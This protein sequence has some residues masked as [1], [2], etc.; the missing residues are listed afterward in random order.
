MPMTRNA[1]NFAS[2]TFGESPHGTVPFCSA[3]AIC[4]NTSGIEMMERRDPGE[5]CFEKEQKPDL[6][7]LDAASIHSL[8]YTC[9]QVSRGDPQCSAT[10]WDHYERVQSTQPSVRQILWANLSAV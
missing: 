7:G 10:Q 8:Q 1:V 2:S 5:R 4:N 3:K 6:S 9:G